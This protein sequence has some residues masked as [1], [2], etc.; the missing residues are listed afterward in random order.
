MLRFRPIAPKPT[1]GE[2]VSGTAEQGRQAVAG[3]RVKRKYVRR[4]RG[5]QRKSKF[6]GGGK[7]PSPPEKSGVEDAPPPEKGAAA[8]PLLG[9]MRSGSDQQNL[10]PKTQENR[11]SISYTMAG[12]RAVEL[13]GGGRSVMVTS[14]IIEC[15]TENYTGVRLGFS[16]KEKIYNLEQDTCPGFVSDCTNNVIWANQAYKKMVAE[17]ESAPATAAEKAFL[18]P[19][20]VKEQLPH[21]CPSFACRVRVTQQ[22]GQGRKWNKIVPCDVW[23]MEFGGFPWKLDV[24]T[25]LSLG[26]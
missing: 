13:G 17:D 7:Q 4:V 24:N 15:V 18:V 6:S 5:G 3:R 22:K 14:M 25:A 12:G 16:D 23:R 8:V 2:A 26:F 20:V 9:E 11:C 1:G 10:I 21:L 19:L